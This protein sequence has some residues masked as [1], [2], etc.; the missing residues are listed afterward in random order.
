M[1]SVVRTFIAV[2]IASGIRS[3]I[4]KTIRP[5]KTHFPGIKWVD[6]ANFHVTLKFLGDVP[7]NELYH[8]IQA[9]EKGCQNIEPFDLVFNG[10]GAFPDSFS[11]R[12][13]W[14][15]VSDGVEEIRTLGKQIDDALHQIGYPLES[16]FFTPHLTIGRARKEDRQKN[17]P[18]KDTLDPSFGL[19]SKMISE[20]NDHYFGCC[21]VDEVVIYSSEL[22]RFGPKYDILAAVELKDQL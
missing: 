9:V 14:V 8:L 10:L 7:A 3:E 18:F 1:K 15:G 22:N 5:F 11:P 13:L 2:D 17:P 6:N 21:A 19:L 16:R 20:Q 4:Q 12:T